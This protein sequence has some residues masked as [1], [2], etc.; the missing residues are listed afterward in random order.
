[1][2]SD[3]IC[4]CGGPSQLTHV[5]T[6][7][8]SFLASMYDALNGETYSEHLKDTASPKFVPAAHI[9]TKRPHVRKGLI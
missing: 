7:T 9:N 6:L 2:P 8:L 4:A 5:A 1:M 3:C